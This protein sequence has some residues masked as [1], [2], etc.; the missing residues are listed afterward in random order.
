[1][2]EAGSIPPTSTVSVL[3]GKT[4]NPTLPVRG[5]PSKGRGHGEISSR[6]LLEL[7]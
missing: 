3:N 5:M 2:V 4:R 7:P 1:M 6:A